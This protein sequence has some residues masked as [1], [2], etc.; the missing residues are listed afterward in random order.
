MSIQETIR[1][2]LKKA[3]K[4]HDNDTVS[5][6]RGL[7]SEFTNEL[8]DQKK[9]PSDE[10]SD[11]A[12]LSAIKRA[13][14]QRKDSI[15]QYKSGNRE[16]LARKEEEELTIIEKYLPEQMSYEQVEQAV[17][18]KIDELGITDASQM[19]QLMKEVMADLKDKADGKEVKQAVDKL[20]S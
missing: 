3:M 20:L 7:L 4:E 18:A 5:V 8:V 10:L 17:K 9:K 1:E 11:D 15:E 12:A 19:G 6:L 13:A 14:K 16:D 2:D